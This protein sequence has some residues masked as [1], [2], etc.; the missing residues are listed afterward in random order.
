MNIGN[1]IREIRKDRG[2]TQ[3]ELAEMV[4]MAVN[5]IRLYEAGK[6]IPSI[7]QRIKIA[8]KL[9][10]SPYDLM[11]EEE[12]RA[13]ADAAG[14]G[15]W[16]RDEELKAEF[17][18]TILEPEIELIGHFNKLNIHGQKEAIRCVEIIAGNPIYQRNSKPTDNLTSSEGK[19]TDNEK[20]P[21]ESEK[22][23]SDGK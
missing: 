11:T 15:Y 18:Y 9:D 23:P 2:L 22:T 21:S 1:A 6:R 17:G 5:S 16:S 20:K 3:L 14:I 4:G 12:E 8:E 19:D 10:C 7:D 13:F